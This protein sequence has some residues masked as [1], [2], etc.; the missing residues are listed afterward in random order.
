MTGNLAQVDVTELGR[1]GLTRMG[2][3]VYEEFL[4]Q[5]QGTKAI[6]VYKEMS[7][8]DPV[9]GAILFA[10]DMLLRQV[11]WRVEPASSSRADQEA[12]E[13][14]RSCLEDMSTTWQDTISEILSMLIYG[15]S[16][17]EIVYK[18]RL[19][20]Q[21][22]PTKRS[23]YN[24]GR[25]GWRKLPG[26]AQDTLY[27]WRFDEAGGVQG[28]V[29]QPPPDYQLREI[30]IEKALHFRTTAQKGDPQGRSI[31]RNAYRPW[32]FKKHIEE[33]EGIGIERD[34]AG[35]PVAWVPPQLL[36]PNATAEDKVVLEA[37]KKIVV[38]VRRDE[39]EGIVFP[40][41]YDDRGNKL[42]DFTLLS[43]GGRRQ[44]DTDGI[45]ARYD[46]R[47]A[48]TILADFILLGHEKVG[49]FALSSSKTHLF[50]VA[51]GA[52]LDSI[53][54]VFNRHAIPRLFALNDFKVERL[55]QLVH[56][57]IETPD[58]KELGEFVK[59]LAG[60]GMELFPDDKL[61][62]YLRQAAK[63]PPKEVEAR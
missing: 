5:L 46:Q 24:D 27:E 34:L 1:T 47:I 57:D 7:A 16:Y 3:T 31:L 42:Y 55:P 30:P 32:Y 8:N 52:W 40:L 53:A 9:V 29:Q 4:P 58:L 49:S 41:V 21:R 35:L 50:A 11:S 12:A 10:V 56:G 6:R 43:T 28:M 60:T 17:H 15:W 13:F 33:I 38:N 14:L 26:R 39:Q 45:V 44:F 19:G 22:D 36:S 63:L 25:I 61:E 18:R 62:N 23:R 48:M 20:D 54:A 51:L 37:I 59:N 2:G